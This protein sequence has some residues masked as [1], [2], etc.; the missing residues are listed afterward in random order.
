MG[1][2]A[3]CRRKGVQI[4]RARRRSVSRPI[5]PAYAPL[6]VSSVRRGTAVFKNGY[7]LGGPPLRTEPLRQS[8][9]FWLTIAP[10]TLRRAD[11]GVSHRKLYI[12]L[13]STPRSLISSAARPFNILILWRA[14]SLERLLTERDT[15]DTLSPLSRPSRVAVVSAFRRC[16]IRVSSFYWTLL[17]HSN[18]GLWSQDGVVLLKAGAKARG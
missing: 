2:W 12:S 14:Q 8:T 5:L 6:G 15:G 7:I 17:V 13:T 11:R 16:H 9:V 18:C 4:R 1:V 3:G 10:I